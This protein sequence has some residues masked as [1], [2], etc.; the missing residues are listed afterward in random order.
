MYYIGI[1]LIMLYNI[2]IFINYGIMYYVW[3]NGCC[4]DGSVGWYLVVT[5][6]CMFFLHCLLCC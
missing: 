3:N 5:V 1:G 6:V 4:M 2:G